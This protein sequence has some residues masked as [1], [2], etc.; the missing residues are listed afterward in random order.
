MRLA[1]AQAW[2][3]ATRGEVPVGAVAVHE[4]RIVG[5]GCNRTICGRDPS[6]HAEIVALRAAGRCLDNYRLPGLRLYV[7]LEPCCMCAMA[8]IHARVAEL[9]FGAYDE[10]TGACG[11]CFDLPA[12]PR[13]NHRLTVRGGI[14]L[15]PCRELLLAFFR[16]RR[17]AAAA[18]AAAAGAAPAGSDAA[19]A[20]EAGGGDDTLRQRPAAGHRL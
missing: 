5:T 14:L 17:P 9:Y 7:T 8:M 10:R 12:D 6:A 11:S 18:D 20:E 13:H 4:G 3:A 15:Q 16:Q 19:P 2:L 1:L